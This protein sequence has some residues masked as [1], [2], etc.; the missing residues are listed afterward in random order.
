MAGE[1]S[2]GALGTALGLTASTP[3]RVDELLHLGAEKEQHIEAARQRKAAADQKQR[4]MDL[5]KNSLLIDKTDF[6]KFPEPLQGTAQEYARQAAIQLHEDNLN[7]R[8]EPDMEEA[9]TKTLT[10]YNSDLA[11]LAKA[12]EN[13]KFNAAVPIDKTDWWGARQ[14][15][16]ASQ[17]TKENVDTVLGGD[18]PP[19]PFGF[20]YNS[21]T[22]AM[23]KAYVDKKPDDWDKMFTSAIGKGKDYVT[24]ISKQ[25]NLA[26][27][28]VAQITSSMPETEADAQAYAKQNHLNFIPPS[29]QSV[30]NVFAKDHP[31]SVESWLHSQFTPDK[32][33]D[34][35]QEL[36]KKYF[37]AVPSQTPDGK[38][39]TNYIPKTDVI[40]KDFQ[41]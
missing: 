12:G 6:S 33:P 16:A 24:T 10:K 9:M 3:D 7:N 41:Q 30:A 4:D 13:Y 29:I 27:N 25:F 38:V 22:G 19:N 8:L 5:E 37:T 31:Q 28:V 17:P 35:I 23:G 14:A 2:N 20:T 26:D 32:S 18:L 39:I 36:T 21:E 1:F 15:L 40:Q 34:E 11:S